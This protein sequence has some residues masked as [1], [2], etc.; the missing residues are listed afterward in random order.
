MAHLEPHDLRSRH[1]EQSRYD[2]AIRQGCMTPCPAE[3]NGL[4]LRQLFRHDWSSTPRCLAVAR[5]YAPAS[6]E[7]L[8]RGI[9]SFKLNAAMPNHISRIPVASQRYV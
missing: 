3:K 7:E 1:Q 9:K 6:A 4:N 5:K 2:D 8:N